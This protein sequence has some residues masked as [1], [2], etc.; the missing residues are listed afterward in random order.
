MSDLFDKVSKDLSKAITKEHDSQKS[1][2]AQSSKNESKNS[3]VAAKS[4]EKESA[5]EVNKSSKTPSRNPNDNLSEV[6]AA[7]FRELK[8]LLIA[9]NSQPLYEEMEDEYDEPFHDEAIDE[10]DDI[11][12]SLAEDVDKNDGVGPDVIPSLA[13]LANKLLQS[14]VDDTVVK[15]K[16]EVYLR[17]KNVE[18][19]NA[20]KLNKPIWETISHSTRIRES[21]LQSIQ[22]DMLSSAVPIINV[23]EKIYYAKDDLSTL[24]ATDLI[25]TLKDSFIFLGSANQN[26]VKARRD[27][28][29]RDLPKQMQG[30]CTDVVKFSSTQ[31][32]GDNLQES[33]KNVSELNKVAF[34]LKPRGASTYRQGTRGSFGRGRMRGFRGIRRGVAASRGYSRRSYPYRIGKSQDNK[35]LNGPGPS[36]K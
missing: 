6:I 20:P 10:G 31:L 28:I 12:N 35:Q 29:R 14:N 36:R 5:T 22:K 1:T 26:L 2:K 18:Y 33:I 25:T 23:M 9:Q 30:L 16:H 34:N 7:G 13:S 27:N 17:P 3:N 15:A 21:G 4:K 24:D 32:F 19:L 11:F 8:E